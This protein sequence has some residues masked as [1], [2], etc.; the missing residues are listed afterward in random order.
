MREIITIIPPG[1][2]FIVGIISLFMAFKT[3]LSRKYLPFHEQTAGKSWEDIETP[4]KPVILSLM[5]LGGL[6]FL[7]TGI[8][9]VVCP[10]AGYISGDTF[11]KY[12]IPGMALVFCSG[13]FV[14]NYALFRKTGANTPWKGSLYAILVLSAGLILSLFSL[15]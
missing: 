12:F 1:L 5:R 15:S 14:I 2:Y 9:L 13:L 10:V 11:L 3:M 4:V 7:I 8:L 6:G